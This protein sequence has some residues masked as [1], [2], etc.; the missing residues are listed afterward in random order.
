M[1]KRKGK[2]LAGFAIV[3]L[4]LGAICWDMVTSVSTAIEEGTYRM[5]SE[6]DAITAATTK[7]AVV[8]SD[9]A[10]LAN[11][12]SRTD[13]LGYEHI[14]DMVRKAIELQGGLDNVVQKGDKVM[15]KPNIVEKDTPY[16]LGTNTDYR[17]VKALI[18]IIAEHTGNDVEIIVA[19]GIPRYDYDDPTSTHSSWEASGYRTLL[20]DD[21]LTGINFYLFNLNQTYDDLEKVDLGT[22]G[23][24]APHG[25]SYRIHKKELEADVYI[26]VPVLKIHDTGITCALKNQIGTAPGA[27]YGYNKMGT[28]VSAYSR[29]VHDVGHRRW[30]TEEIVDLSTIAGIDFVVVDAIMCLETNK[31][32]NGSNQ[33][34]F[35]TIIAGVDPVAVD[36]VC[37]RLFCMNP[38]DIAHI[39]LAEKIGLGT[40]DPEK[41]EVY[42]APIDEIRKKV[43]QNTSENGLFGQGNRTWVLSGT[44]SG[45][46]M[47]A[48]QISGEADL[49][50]VAGENGFSQP[51]YFFDDR[52]DLLSYYSGASSIITYAFT[53]FYA[54]RN[55]QALL[56]VG[57]DESMIVYINGEKAY[58]YSGT[59]SYNEDK[60]NIENDSKTINLKAGEN[61][62]LVKTL[63][64]YGDYSFALN[65]CETE[66][67]PN[68]KGNRIDGLKFY[69][70]KKGG[71]STTLPENY[72]DNKLIFENYPNPVV[73]EATIRFELPE[74]CNT[75]VDIYDTGGR[76]IM[77]LTDKN[78]RSGIHYLPWSVSMNGQR[79]PSGIYICAIR[80]AHYTNSIRISVTE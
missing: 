39:T 75:T 66:T 33:V 24:A 1:R 23:T 62:L 71:S 25:Y 45:T 59:R 49:E 73:S 21:D 63:N 28:T 18:R 14:E 35:N 42:G 70:A 80:S 19:E 6:F 36:N 10:G 29:L 53:Y 47:S 37:T 56:S 2:K 5:E 17:V 46:D 4:A 60:Y 78:L 43:R 64:K 27:Y 72:S 15:L 58:E 12:R 8:P 74:T 57:S 61:K 50:P 65:I 54:P 16:G 3:I 30:T 11:K 48:E 41:I 40:N 7:V 52:I 69:T 22:K 26:T 31:T 32:Y 67:D 38:D 55:E 79:L 77:N 34:R 68:Y 13:T 44:F 51:V 76:H 20:A 9:Y